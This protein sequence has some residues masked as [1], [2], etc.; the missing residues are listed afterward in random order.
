MKL[1]N[2]ESSKFWILNSMIDVNGK[3]MGG[4]KEPPLD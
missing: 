2:Y 1:G 4:S 3:K